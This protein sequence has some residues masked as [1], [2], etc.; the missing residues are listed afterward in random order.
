MTAPAAGYSG[1]PLP[2]KLGIKEGAS[3]LVVDGP[4]EVEA[5]VDPLPP[6]VDWRRGLRSKGPFDVVWL[7]APDLASLRRRWPACRQRL[8][9][10]GGLWVSWPKGSSGVATDLDGNAV[11]IFGL[12][13]GLV[14]N[15]VCAVSDVWSGLRFVVRLGD[16]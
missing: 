16:R 14:D 13:H 10:D 9:V 4:P 5:L 15:K 11:R 1:T 6:G 8:A 2:K 7:F 12:D 3:V